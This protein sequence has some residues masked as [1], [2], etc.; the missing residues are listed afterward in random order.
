[1]VDSHNNG[2]SCMLMNGRENQERENL[3]KTSDFTSKD[4]SISNLLW[5][6]RD[7]S[8]LSTVDRWLSRLQTVTRLKSGGSTNNHSQ[9]R[10]S[11]TTNHL[12]SNHLVR[13][14]TC[15]SGA[16]T[17]NGSRSSSSKQDNSSTSERI[18]RFLMSMVPRM[19]KLERLLSERTQVKLTRNGMSSILIRLLRVK[20]KDSMK[21]SVSTSTDHSIS[22]LT[23]Q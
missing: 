11:L 6:L 2:I 12:I 4:H 14:M 19:R 8:K 3:M 10:P 1:M 5:E 16:P 22:D 21:N 7:T 15:K 20:L 9:S 13:L 23:C 18:K 17:H